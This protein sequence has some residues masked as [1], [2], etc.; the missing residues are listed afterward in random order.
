MVPALTTALPPCRHRRRNFTLTV[1]ATTTPEDAKDIFAEAQAAC[2][3]VVGA[4]NDDNV[5]RLNEAFINALQSIDVPGGAVDLSGILLSDEDHKAK[6]GGDKTF[7]RMEVPLQAYNY[8][9]AADANNAVQAKPE[10]LWTAKIEFQRLIKTVERA[11]RAFLVAVVK[12]TWLPPLKEESTFYNKAPLLDFFVHLNGG[13]GTLEA[14]DIV[15]L[16]STML[17]WWAHKSL[18]PEYVNHLEDAQK[19]SV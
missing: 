17:G 12:D 15:S 2:T 8:S 1:R 11:G 16:L 13:S 10:R 5:K 18:V 19:K 3:P 7:K 9:I 4:P 6:H 14:T